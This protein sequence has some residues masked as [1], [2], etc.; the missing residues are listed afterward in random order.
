MAG[1]GCEYMGIYR[2]IAGITIGCTLFGLVEGTFITAYASEE[3]LVQYDVTSDERDEY[4]VLTGEIG[5]YKV[6]EGDTLWRISETLLGNGKN[7]TQLVAQNASLISNSNL[8]YPNM[9]LQVKQNVYV[10][11]RMGVNGLK[12]SEYQF[13]TQDL[14]SFGI[15]ES[16]KAFANC[17]LFGE[18]AA[19]VICLIRDKEQAGEKT[20]ADWENS[21]Q[22]IESYVQKNYA[23]RISDLTFYDYLTEDGRE[24]H[25]FS[26]I[27]TIDEKQ[28]GHESWGELKIYVC[29]GICQTEHIQAEFTGFDTKEGVQ[30]VVLYMLASFEEFPEANGASV[31]GYNVQIAPCDP[32]EVAGI[33]NSFAW[34]EQYFNGVLDEIS[35][36]PAER[37]N[38]RERILG[39]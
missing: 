6:C 7:Y 26:Y 24:L 14:A 4:S 18:E 23:D 8:I 15:L 3:K 35:Q 31:N 25:L 37:K 27:Y 2:A 10:K 33:H 17:A 34:I 20:L 5:T 30:D 28:H 29:E 32:W 16:G 36:K 13:G 39:E 19:N 21:R 22:K 38:A 1:K 11:K 12:T 9:Q